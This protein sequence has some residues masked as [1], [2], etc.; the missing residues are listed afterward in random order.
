MKINGAD[1]KTHDKCPEC[2]WSNDGECVG[3]AYPDYPPLDEVNLFEATCRMC[4]HW[5]EYVKTKMIS[6]EE[7][8]TKILKKAEEE[9]KMN[10]VV[11]IT[12]RMNSG[13]FTEVFKEMPSADRVIKI[14]EKYMEI[15]LLENDFEAYADRA[16][17]LYT[18]A[19]QGLPQLNENDEWTYVEDENSGIEIGVSTTQLF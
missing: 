13:C 14:T 17:I 11:L 4:G 19:K 18:L 8:N 15:A 3:V 10:Q 12:F 7:S 1:L 6:V 16:A 9:E 5:Y 2:A